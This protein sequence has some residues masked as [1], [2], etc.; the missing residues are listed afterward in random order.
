[1]QKR[2]TGR[3]GERSRDHVG[4]RL[5]RGVEAGKIDSIRFSTRPDT[6]D[7]ERLDLLKDYPLSTIE[8]GVQSMDDDVLT[9]SNR[10]HTA[11]DTK[12]AVSLLKERNYEIGL[13]MMVGLPG[14]NEKKALA[15]GHSIAGMSPDFVR[16]Y[17]TVVLANSLLALWYTQGKYSP[18]SLERCITLVKHLYLLFKENKIPVIRMGLQSSKNLDNG[19]TILA[20][21]YH[22]AFG[23]L[24]FSEIFL[25]KAASIIKSKLT[26][27]DGITL[28]VH[29]SSVSKMRGMKNINTD[30]LKKQF[31]IKTLKILSDPD[32]AEDEVV[33]SSQKS[34]TR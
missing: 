6:V 14:D 29:P 1:M 28:K 23:H 30:I 21:P 25:D 15:T 13:Q 19:T 26:M 32:L 7:D 22:P 2:R 17:P 11:S 12:K 3:Q 8:L 5:A 34:V 10:G 20:G 33:V 31:H 18:L 9:I 16:I 27:H 24:V 4:C